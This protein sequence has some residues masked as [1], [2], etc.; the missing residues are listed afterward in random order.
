[1]SQEVWDGSEDTVFEEFV[2]ES[3]T[4]IRVN[5]ANV[6]IE[7]GTSFISAV[8]GAAQSAGLGKFR[9]FLNDNEIKP[10]ESPEIVEAGSRMELRPYDVAGI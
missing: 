4:F 5:G 7:P 10:S 9:V 3:D 2:Q 1:M 8:K 6:P